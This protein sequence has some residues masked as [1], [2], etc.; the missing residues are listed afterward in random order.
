M[1]FNRCVDFKIWLEKIVKSH[2][3]N[4]EKYGRLEGLLID[5]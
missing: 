2:S 3:K 5:I 4:C 1:K